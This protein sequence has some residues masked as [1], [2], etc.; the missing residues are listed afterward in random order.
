MSEEKMDEERKLKDRGQRGD[1]CYSTCNNLDENHWKVCLRKGE[2][3]GN[4]NNSSVTSPGQCSVLQEGLAWLKGLAT[5]PR[6]RRL[7]EGCHLCVDR[8]RV[9]PTTSIFPVSAP[10]SQSLILPFFVCGDFLT[11]WLSEE[12]MDE[13]RKLK[14]RGQR[15]E[16]VATVLVT[17][18]MRTIGRSL[19]KCD[20]NN[21]NLYEIPLHLW[22]F[23]I[24]QIWQ[25][26]GE[27]IAWSRD[28]VLV[29][30]HLV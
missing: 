6:A 2:L 8:S 24:N 18:L 20:D 23:S 7:V 9:A 17:I 22:G 29:L 15:E 1:I 26:N 28:A 13:E 14:D 19:N 4:N 21:N 3:H 12:K 30:L 27:R 11:H 10:L 25:Q 16:T 5:K